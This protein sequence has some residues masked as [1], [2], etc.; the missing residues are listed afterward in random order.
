MRHPTSRTY[1]TPFENLV[2][3]PALLHPSLR[4]FVSGFNDDP[5]GGADS[6]TFTTIPDYRVDKG[7]RCLSKLWDDSSCT[8]VQA[9]Y[10]VGLEQKR[11]LEHEH[12]KIFVEDSHLV[13][14]WESNECSLQCHPLQLKKILS[15]RDWGVSFWS[16]TP[17]REKVDG[18]VT[19]HCFI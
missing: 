7:L 13:L 4:R 17:A 14:C 2:F 5:C 6:G 19:M 18:T 11:W 12:L 1:S 16:F 9:I 10:I 15:A 8:S 3:G